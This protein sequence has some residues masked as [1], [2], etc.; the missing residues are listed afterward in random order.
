MKTEGK[1]MLGTIKEVATA[2]AENIIEG[3]RVTRTSIR[4]FKDCDFAIPDEIEATDG[5][6]EMI[7]DASGGNYGIKS[8]TTGFDNEDLNLFADYYGGGSG[9]YDCIFVDDDFKMVVDIIQKLI[10]GTLCVR[11]I[12][13]KD[14]IIIAEWED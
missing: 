3:N 7:M 12:C 2:I 11:D 1:Y 9:Q 8:I 10:V 4:N 5:S 6:L 13:D 14:D